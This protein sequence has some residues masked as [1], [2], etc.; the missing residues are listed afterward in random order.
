MLRRLEPMKSVNV[1]PLA[2]LAF[3][4]SACERRVETPGNDT[5]S[6]TVTLPQPIPDSTPVRRPST[7]DSAAGPLFVVMG[8][9]TA[10]ATLVDP[11]IDSSASLDTVSFDVRGARSLQLD[12]FNN[13][14]P[15]TQSTVGV[16]LRT[17]SL[18]DCAL[19]PLVRVGTRDDVPRVSWIVGF[20]R[21][22]VAAIPVDSVENLTRQDSLKLV[23][24]LARLASS[25]PGD[26][27]ESLRGLPFVVR[28]SARGH[29]PSGTE[30]LL[31]EID[32]SLN[33]E[34]SPMLEHLLLVAE[35]DS[36]AGAYRRAYVERSVGGE[37]RVES[38]EVLLVGRIRS[39]DTPFILL[40]RYLGDG[41]IYSLLT[42]DPT[43]TW[44]RAWSSPYAGC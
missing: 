21:D 37:E 4:A 1:L 35:R 20:K 12:L 30:L 36:A 15:I 22:A 38:Y 44:R 24:Q 29:L 5:P 3:A 28:R 7:W 33:Q 19:W 16:S 26:T 13:G 43:G 11:T 14:R 40:A 32:R 17:D 42:R 2:C 27:V 9:T 25:A 8:G 23:A 34:A 41:V 31:A 18:V 6:G 39:R 10:E